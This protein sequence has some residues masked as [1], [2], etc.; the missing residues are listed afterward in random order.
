MIKSFK[1]TELFFEK[2]G[3]EAKKSSKCFSRCLKN[4]LSEPGSKLEPKLHVHHPFLVLLHV[5]EV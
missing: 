2:R 1:V 3:Q 5:V 4:I